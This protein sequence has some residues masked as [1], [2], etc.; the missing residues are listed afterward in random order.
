MVH[1][2]ENREI[3]SAKALLKS[4]F[5]ELTQGNYNQCEI[6]TKEAQEIL[7][8][9]NSNENISICLSML[10]FVKYMKDANNYQKEI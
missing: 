5:N 4:A 1:A 6:L 8:N 2:L 3:I 9:E 10:G 7:K